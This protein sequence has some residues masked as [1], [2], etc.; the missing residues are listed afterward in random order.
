MNSK[1]TYQEE[2]NNTFRQYAIAGVSDANFVRLVDF[3]RRVGMGIDYNRTINGGKDNTTAA[4]YI[5][6]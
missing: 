3:L 2:L 4:A 1:S 5:K 6:K